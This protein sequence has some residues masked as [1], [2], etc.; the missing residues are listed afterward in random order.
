MN[1]IILLP[2]WN[3]CIYCIVICIQHNTLSIENA[4]TVP[5]KNNKSLFSSTDNKGQI[6]P[7]G[8]YSSTHYEIG[9]LSGLSL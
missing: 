1:I 4:S 9:I 7:A 5:N 8:K 3:H 6:I 2:N